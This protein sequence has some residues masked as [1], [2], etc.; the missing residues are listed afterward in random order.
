M[1]DHD[2]SA[3]S[4]VAS[5]DL[6]APKTTPITAQTKRK[7]A[8]TTA[9][10]V[11]IVSKRAR[12]LGSDGIQEQGDSPQIDEATSTRRKSVKLEKRAPEE[13]SAGRKAKKNET[14]KTKKRTKQAVVKEEAI[15]ALVQ[16]EEKPGAKVKVK[17]PRKT[18]EEK[19]AEAMPM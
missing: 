14:V 19:E 18:K 7:R 9:K 16:A 10:S 2:S 8:A 1:S 3:L 17:R 15:E 11:T 13:D 6:T 12:Q 4:S 5:T